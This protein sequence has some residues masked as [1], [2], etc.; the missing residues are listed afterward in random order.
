MTSHEIPEAISQR[1]APETL[2]ASSQFFRAALDALSAHIALL[3]ASGTIISV[4]TAWRRFAETNQ[5]NVPFYGVGMNYLEV[6]E[7][8]SGPG[9]VE[10][11]AVARGIHEVIARQR[12]IFS[13][14]YPCHSPEEQRW[15]MIRVSRIEDSRTSGVVIVHENITGHKQAEAAQK[16]SEQKF[17]AVVEGSLDGF[18][19]LE[20]ERDERGEII[21]F[22]FADMNGNA[23][24]QLSMSR[25]TLLGRRIC[26]VFPINRTGSYFEKYKRIAETGQV[27]EEE[28]L[29]PS[30]E[31]KP[32][33]WWHQ[34]VPLADGVAIF[35]RDISEEKWSEQAIRESEERFRGLVEGSIQGILVH[36]NT[37]ALFANRAYAR[38]LGYNSPAEI[39]AMDSVMPLI[40]P[41]EQE[42]LLGYH[43]ARVKGEAAP[44]QYE[45]DAICKDGSMV[46]LQQLVTMIP[47][48]GEPAVLAAIIDITE[49]KRAVEELRRSEGRLKQAQRLARLGVWEWDLAADE[50]TWS[51]EMFPMYGIRPDE[52]TGKGADYLNFTHPDDRQMQPDNIQKA[53][54]KVVKLQAETGQTSVMGPD[55]KEFRLVRPDGSICHVRGDA[56]AIVDE[57]GNPVRMLGILMDIT[58]EKER[59]E[60]LRFQKMLLECQSEASPDGILI[61]SNDRKWLSYNQRFLEVWRYSPRVIE[62]RSSQIALQEAL[63]QLAEPEQFLATTEH[64]YAHPDESGHDELR[65]KDGRIIE[66]HSAPVKDAAGLHYGRVWYFRDITER[67]QVEEAL[68]KSEEKYRSLFEMAGDAILIVRLPDG[69]IL[70]ANMVT[71]KMLGYSKEELQA[72]DGGKDVIAPEVLEE[73]E[74]AWAAQ[75]ANQGDFLVE[76]LWVRK[77]GSR[78]PVAV[79]GKPV[80][81][82]DELLIQ[83]IG[84]DITERVQAEKA[85][86]A[87]ELKY[88]TL[89]EHI[90]AITYIAALDETSATL[91]ISPRQIEEIL[92]FRPEEWQAEGRDIWFQQLHPADRE[93]VLAE[94]AAGY[95]S[96]APFVREYRMFSRDERVVWIRDEAVVVRDEAGQPLFRQGIMSDITALKQAEAELRRR[97]RELSLLNQVIAASAAGLEPV[98]IL[99]TACR[100]LALA[101]EAPQATAALLNEDKTASTIVAEYR[102]K[103]RPSALGHVIPAENNPVTP[104]VL[105]HKAHLVV[106]DARN[107]P[108]LPVI[109]ELTHQRGIVS[110]LI[111][112]LII[113]GEV[114]GS[115]RLDTS[116]PR[117]FSIEEVNLAWSVAD[118]VA[119][120]LARA[121]LGQARRLLSAA[122]EQSAESVIITDTEGTIIYVNSTFEQASGYSLTEALGQTPRFLK[123]GRQEAA[124]YKELW[125]TITAGQ[126]WHGRLTNK[127]KD[128]KLYTIDAMITPVRDE[129]GEIVNY[130]ALQR[131][132]TRELQ[133]EEQLRQSQKMEAIGRLA[134]GVAHDF[135]NLLT[136]I[137]GHTEFLADSYLNSDDPRRKDIEQIK[138]AGERAAL[139]TRQLLAF[140]RQQPTQLHCLNLNQVI[141]NLENMLRRLL[142]EHLALRI[143][144]APDLGYVLA[145]HGQLEQIMMNLAVNARDAMP[146]G[147]KLT[148]KT[149][150]ISLSDDEASRVLNLKPGPYVLLS[151]TDTGV[152]MD[153]ETRSHMFEPFYTTKAAGKGTGLGLAIVY[154]IVEQSNGHIQVESELGQGTTFRIYLPQIEQAAKT[155]PPV[156]ASPPAA[157]G[158][159]TILLVEDEAGVRLVTR[160]FLEKGGYT[161]LEASHAEEALYLCQQYQGRTDL[162]ITDV[163]MPDI[164]GPELAGQLAQLYPS[165]KV[166]YIS[167]YTDEELKEHRVQNTAPILLKK[168]FTSDALAR[169]VRE[170]LDMPR[171]RLGE[172]NI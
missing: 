12:E 171:S 162:L 22:I 33:W 5:L 84:R 156:K 163:V 122:V 6:C 29:I 165:L 130:V 148:L 98:T 104:Y 75:L 88:R 38:I 87:S 59:E 100:E 47:W 3:D 27:L 44:A 40:A 39:L 150:N 157:M 131:D 10:A 24:K 35:N 37:K 144:L 62:G 123:S 43:A 11:L 105:T 120:G 67:K 154:G 117:A 90:P 30:T 49:R 57:Q 14:E 51:E 83:L 128:G 127:K 34:V 21:D 170:V 168:P 23:E 18:F 4:N 106:E 32:G 66:R 69:K 112:P 145:D 8:A 77:D 9:Q 13:L 76:T 132:V 147:G 119:G 15:F 166:L 109:H 111:L 108:R 96:P 74:Y 152:G 70:D 41:H 143:D 78:F 160:K 97:N 91:Y 1:Q 65:F 142:G 63:P 126:V 149:A 158:H 86:R 136:V 137:S 125:A 159:E 99:E 79:S 169:K 155:A 140:S 102:A 80:E 45:Y 42:R 64:L 153:E 28:F 7:T 121:R 82:K 103:G 135:N 50:T 58:A 164:S 113:E 92:G 107:D 151:I 71:V 167:G 73:T 61:V 116:E 134:G 141:T 95:V 172:E 25:E 56:V 110:R 94:A 133:L 53:F 118:Q 114:I 60:A 161:V 129:K 54:E 101:F 138:R 139:L 31:G 115:L 72:L 124:F 26:E 16:K 17:R 52:F 81:I 20:A 2:Q 89:I 55:P 36:R 93:R 19:L 146:G 85:L 46:T 48:D 68:R